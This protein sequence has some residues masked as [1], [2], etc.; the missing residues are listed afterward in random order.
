MSEL[1]SIESAKSKLNAIH[2]DRKSILIDVNCARGYY[3]AE[4]IYAPI[5]LPSFRQSAMDGYAI[6]FSAQNTLFNITGEIQAGNNSNPRLSAGEAIR[7][8]TGAAVP[9]DAQAVIMQEKTKRNGQKLTI[10]EL[11]KTEENIRPIGEQIKKGDLAIPINSLINPAM[12]GFL[13]SL[14]ISQIKAFIKPKISILTTGDELISVGQTLNRG[15]VY[16]SNKITLEELV[17]SS[18]FEITASRQ[19]RDNYAETVSQI[20]E[21]SN[22]SDFLIITGGISVGDYDYVGKA[23][24]ALDSKKIFHGVKQKP[25]KPL[26]LGK[27]DNCLIFGLPGNPAAA[28]TCFYE[29]VF[30]SLHRFS[31]AEKARL[32]ALQLPLAHDYQK[33]G[34]RGQFLKARIENNEIQLLNKQNSSMMISYIAVDGIVYIPEDSTFV[35]KGS[36]VSIHLLP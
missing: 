12:M 27:K 3:L 15:Q 7:I 19:V 1:Q 8:F 25:G 13:H 9:D 20:R 32:V 4:D 26:Y 2:F 30:E 21:L 34:S 35:E 17:L 24:Q 5:S 10:N 36:M 6:R 11:P 28:F 14:G 31:G 23:L 16:E 18:G 22:I 33:K 29:Y